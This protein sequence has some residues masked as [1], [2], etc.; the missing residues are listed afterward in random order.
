MQHKEIEAIITNFPK[1]I[2]HLRNIDETYE[3]EEALE[4]MKRAHV[5]AGVQLQRKINDH[6]VCSEEGKKELKYALESDGIYVIT[7]P[8]YTIVAETFHG[9]VK[10]IDM[11]RVSEDLGGNGNGLIKV[12]QESK[13]AAKWIWKR[14]YHN[15]VY[16]G[17][18][19]IVKVL[20]TS[21]D[22]NQTENS[23]VE[24]LVDT[25]NEPRI[26]CETVNSRSASQSKA[27]SKEIIEIDDSGD[28]DLDSANNKDEGG[29]SIQNCNSK[30][31]KGQ[32]ESCTK[33]YWEKQDTSIWGPYKIPFISCMDRKLSN[34]EVYAI[35]IARRRVQ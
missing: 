34:S 16:N 27:V 30:T 31:V 35:S 17:F 3:V 23:S 14:M 29:Q 25:S 33:E 1:K 21:N 8:D 4:I 5:L 7:I 24:G 28:E 10:I 22:H 20:P 19:K 2:N 12:F 9:K 13:S 32:Y 26:N 15:T 18:Q 6:R 11:H